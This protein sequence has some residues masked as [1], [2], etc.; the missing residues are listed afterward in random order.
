MARPLHFVLVPLLAQ[1]HVAILS[2]PAVG[3]FLTH[4]GWNSTLES[5]S[6]GVPLLTW[7]HFADQLLNETLVVDVLGAGVRVG[8]KVPAMHVFL[9]PE[10]HAK[11]VG[12]DDVK[13]ALTELMDEGSG[14]RARAKELAT[15]AREAMAEGGS[16]DRDLSV[17]RDDVKRALTELMDEGSGIRARAKELATMARE[18]MAEGGSADRDLAGMA[19]HVGELAQRKEQGVPE[20]GSEKQINGW[21]RQTSRGSIAS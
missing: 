20:L 15:M 16:A 13:R 11:Q 19:R 3:G 10:A 9:N 2:H 21:P 5:I 18:A 8:V 7:P 6:H 12:R 17:G 4:C 1:G 14:I